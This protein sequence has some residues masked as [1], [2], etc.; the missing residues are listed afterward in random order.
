MPQPIIDLYGLLELKASDRPSTG[1]IKK[2]YYRLALKWHPDKLHQNDQSSS[3]PKE[4]TFLQICKAYEIL[5]ND[6]SRAYY[7]ATGQIH[8]EESD[9]LGNSNSWNAFCRRS[10]TG[11]S[12][13]TPEAIRQL[14]QEYFGSCEER[15]D[16]LRFYCK[17]KGN[18]SKILECLLHSELEQLDRYREIVKDVVSKGE[19]EEFQRFFSWKPSKSAQRK[20]R[21][22]QQEAAESLAAL[23]KAIALRS[24]GGGF[25]ERLE[26]KYAKKPK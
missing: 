22:E 20:R 13:I 23:S 5:S 15:E 19:I 3:S 24:Q 26:A 9:L 8:G 6:E 2:A 21:M 7:D 10:T 25:L 12:C 4:E 1:Q 11:E 14:Q 18:V 16:L 17:F